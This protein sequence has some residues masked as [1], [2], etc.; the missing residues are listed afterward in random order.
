MALNSQ[1]VADKWKKNANNAVSDYKAGILAVTE[2]PMDKAANAG[3]KMKQNLIKSIDDG[4]WAAGLRSVS[5]DEWK[6]KT[7][8][9]GANRFATGVNAAAPKMKQFMDFFL[10]EIA[11]VKNE[12]DKMPSL[13]LQDNINRMVYQVTETAKLNYKR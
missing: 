8:E 13:S 11:R 2:S 9:E 1:Q 12:V 4:S 3:E 5:L 7:S 10:P 6:K